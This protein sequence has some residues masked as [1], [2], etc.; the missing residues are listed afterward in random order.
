MVEWSWVKGLKHMRCILDGSSFIYHTSLDIEDF[1]DKNKLWDLSSRL[2]SEKLTGNV[3][4]I[5][6]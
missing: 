1:H 2:I 5:V 6:L 3:L 4:D